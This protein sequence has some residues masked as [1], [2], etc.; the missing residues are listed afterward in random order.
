MMDGNASFAIGGRGHMLEE[1][2]MIAIEGLVTIAEQ[3]QKTLA[4]IKEALVILKQRIE[5]LERRQDARD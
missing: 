2:Q 1:S 3:T 5:A 4:S